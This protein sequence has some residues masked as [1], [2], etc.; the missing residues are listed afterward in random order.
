MKYLHHEVNTNVITRNMATASDT[1]RFQR[2]CHHRHRRLSAL[3]WVI[4]LVIIGSLQV[5]GTASHHHS[6]DEH[7]QQRMQEWRRHQQ[8]QSL[9]LEDHRKPQL[10]DRN[11]NNNKSSQ[12]WLMNSQPNHNPRTNDWAFQ[13]WHRHL[14]TSA[15]ITTTTS[16][17]STTTPRPTP[18]AKT[19]FPSLWNYASKKGAAASN[20]HTN[21]TIS[22]EL[23]PKHGW[24]L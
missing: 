10:T 22:R 4:L 21:R 12:L 9:A 24:V 18:A 5:I 16:T 20:Q 19:P 14:I 11:A 17:T 8:R 13:G 2:P 15:A 7:M 1:E 6:T 23:N 3:L